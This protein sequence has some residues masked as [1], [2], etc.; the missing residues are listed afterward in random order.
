MRTRSTNTRTRST[1]ARPRVRAAHRRGLRLV[2]DRFHDASRWPVIGEIDHEE[3]LRTGE[4]LSIGG[5]L[6]G[7]PH[8]WSSHEGQADGK[9]WITLRG[10]RA[11]LDP[12]AE[13]IGDA[14]QVVAHCV[15][16]YRSDRKAKLRR[17]DVLALGISEERCARFHLLMRYESY[18]FGNGAGDETSDWE[19]D[20]RP[21]IA[22][23]AEVQT[24]DELFAAQHRVELLERSMHQR[25][26]AGQVVSVHDGGAIELNT[27]LL[28]AT[29]DPDL[30]EHVGD[31]IRLQKWTQLASQCAI[32]LESTLR[33]WLAPTSEPYPALAAKAFLPK[34]GRFVLGTSANE[35]DGWFRI[36]HGVGAA[37]RNVDAHRVQRRDDAAQY[38]IGVLGVVS[39]LLTQTKH[40]YPELAVVKRAS[41]RRR[42]G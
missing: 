19:M 10:I 2:Y 12:S 28:A 35:Q 23:F 26:F 32:F 17:A 40:R 42:A 14:L 4:P 3:F 34:T 7:L 13:E 27:D 22:Q 1:P 31:F 37:L 21:S 29:I 20:I 41:R 6:V 15:S 11:A 33:A 30:W 18:L 5:L 39:L 9:V 38:A 36:A 25:R 16:L 8:R 24:I